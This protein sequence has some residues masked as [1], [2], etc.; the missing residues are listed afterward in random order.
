MEEFQDVFDS[1]SSFKVIKGD[2]IKIHLKPSKD[3]KPLH[4]TTTR[5]IPYHFREETEK[6][7]AYMDRMGITEDADEPTPWVSPFLV[8]GKPG[9]GVRLVVDYSA[10]NRHVE[11][12]V[13][14]FPSVSE[15][16]ISIPST[17]KWFAKLDATKGYWQVELDEESKKAY[18]LPYSI[19]PKMVSKSTHGFMQLRGRVL[20]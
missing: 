19:E 17:A 20:S 15:I 16:M 2:P 10:L 4:V 11:R 18:N 6:E 9:G 3:T 12:P 5:P 1:S 8:L 14:P 13:H 7:L